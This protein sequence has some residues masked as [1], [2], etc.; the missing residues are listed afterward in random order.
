MSHQGILLTL[1][2]AQ[3]AKFPAAYYPLWKLDLKVCFLDSDS[4]VQKNIINI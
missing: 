1:S 3:P 4:S 2:E